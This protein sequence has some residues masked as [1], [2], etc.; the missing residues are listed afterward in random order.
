[1]PQILNFYFE[2]S[3]WLTD[4]KRMPIFKIYFTTFIMKKKQLCNY[5]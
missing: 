5:V 1:M 2:V 3:E 4:R